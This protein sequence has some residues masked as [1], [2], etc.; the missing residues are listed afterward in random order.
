MNSI[1][2]CGHH[3]GEHAEA[4]EFMGIEAICFAPGCECTE[5][6]DRHFY[7][8]KPRGGFLE[9]LRGVPEDVVGRF[10]GRLS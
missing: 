4:P 10:T 3:N 2:C 7:R 1:C 6:L 8:H 5:F 9:W